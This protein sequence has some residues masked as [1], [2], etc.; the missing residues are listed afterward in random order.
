MDAAET[1]LS[2]SRTA[3]QTIEEDI[4]LLMRANRTATTAGP[5]EDILGAGATF[6]ADIDKLMEEL[7]MARDYL[8]AEGERVR[9]LT[10]RY[11]HL[12]KIASA[13]VEIIS[14][15]LGKWRNS[16]P[17]TLSEADAATAH[18]EAKAPAWF[19]N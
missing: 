19:P 4:R 15:N 17:D 8:E 12:A 9:R 13:S 7:Q 3:T 10:G 11:A 18:S 2:I 1:G 5:C 16:E 6:I 14:K